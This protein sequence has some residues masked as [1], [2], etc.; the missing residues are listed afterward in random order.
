L[1]VLILRLYNSFAC[2]KIQLPVVWKEVFGYKVGILS[3]ERISDDNCNDRNDP[4]FW[5]AIK[6]VLP[7]FKSNNRMVISISG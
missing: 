6:I 3:D 5:G 1:A 2:K 4:S 7:I